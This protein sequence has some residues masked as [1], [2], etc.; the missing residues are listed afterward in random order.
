[1]HQINTD[2]QTCFFTLPVIVKFML[3]MIY[4]YCWQNIMLKE[5]L[6][7]DTELLEE[8]LIYELKSSSCKILIK[9]FVD[10]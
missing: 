2:Y 8:L 5:N 1:M 4:Q 10:E 9:Y 3:K 7:F 6:S